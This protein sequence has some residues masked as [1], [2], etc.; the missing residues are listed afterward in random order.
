VLDVGNSKIAIYDAAPAGIR[1]IAD[2]RLSVA[3]AAAICAAGSR[4]FILSVSGDR[5]VH[6]VDASGRVTRSF[7]APVTPDRELAREFRGQPS[8]FL[9]NDGRITCSGRYGILYSSFR[10]GEIRRYS[11]SGDLL[12]RTI[13]PGF[14]RGEIKFS[15]ALGTCCVM[16]PDRRTGLSQQAV[17]AV[18]DGDSVVVSVRGYQAGE[19]Y[20]YETR[21]LR[22]SDG[23][24][25]ARRQAPG[26][27]ADLLSDGSR[28]I[29]SQE[30][31]PHVI[32]LR[33][34]R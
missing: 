13:L 8:G 29:Y 26:L 14:V 30:P 15:A 12:W 25:L 31:F 18:A 24:Q 28:L 22:L 9:L 16:G 11:L 27:T 5:L 7:G 2:Q 4:R 33:G 17:H 21:T 19:G 23:A 3:G 6:E 20:R 32:L 1:P 34:A 10:T